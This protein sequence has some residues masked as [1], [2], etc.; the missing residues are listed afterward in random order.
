[1]KIGEIMTKNVITLT[2]DQTVK[3]ALNCFSTNQISGAPITKKGKLVGIVS[4]S[5]L[6]KKAGDLATVL[7]KG[8]EES[9]EKLE[10]KLEKVMTKKVKTLS[11]DNTVWKSIKLMNKH[12]INRIPVVEGK[13]LVGIISR[14]DLV[15]ALSRK[16]AHAKLRL[17]EGTEIKTDVDKLLSLVNKKKKIKIETVSKEL[18]IPSARIEEWSRLLDEHGLLKLE[19]SLGKPVLIS[20]E[21]E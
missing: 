1:M 16:L 12:N 19:Y 11:P 3:D 15:S 6:I 7:K 20:K 8:I 10:I 2:P 18:G 4:E 17:A 14:A 9:K 21:H 5:D 13:K